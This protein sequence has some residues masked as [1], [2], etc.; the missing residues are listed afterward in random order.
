MVAQAELLTR[1]QVP[2]AETWD[3]NTIYRDD[4]A[5]EADLAAARELLTTAAAHRGYLAESAERL[6]RALDDSM[7]LRETLERLF[8]YAR[9]RAGSDDLATGYEPAALDAWAAGS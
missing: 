8:V 9:L 3:L 2:V 7:A 6:R 1:D 4:S 5:W